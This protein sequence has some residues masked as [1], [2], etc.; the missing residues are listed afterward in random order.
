MEQVEDRAPRKEASATSQVAFREMAVAVWQALTL[1]AVFGSGYLTRPTEATLLRIHLSA[2]N[3]FLTGKN[4]ECVSE[5]S[6]FDRH[7]LVPYDPRAR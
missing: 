7:D 4:R 6:H 5:R 3:H 2:I 1:P